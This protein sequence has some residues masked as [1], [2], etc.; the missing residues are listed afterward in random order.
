MSLVRFEDIEGNP[1]G[2]FNWFPVHP[3]SMN[4]TNG[5]I[6]GDNKGVASLL[7]ENVMNPGSLPGQV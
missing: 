2:M 6:S 5:L 3:T 7:F 1:I 4:N